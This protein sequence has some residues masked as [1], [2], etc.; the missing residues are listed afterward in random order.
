MQSA[1]VGQGTSSH[2]LFNNMPLN[3]TMTA[4]VRPHDDEII[5]NL[6]VAGMTTNKEALLRSQRMLNEAE[7]G[8]DGHGPVR[9][10]LE[11]AHRHQSLTPFPI[12]CGEL[13]FLTCIA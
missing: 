13:A 6:R 11:L 1:D 10:N 7:A 4:R 9:S 2:L 8:V 5:P 3:S 12:C